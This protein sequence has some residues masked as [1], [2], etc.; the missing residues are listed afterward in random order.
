[1]VAIDFQ[2]EDAHC[3]LLTISP[4]TNTHAAQNQTSCWQLSINSWTL[5]F[6]LAR[7]T[8]FVRLLWYDGK[9]KFYLARYTSLRTS[10]V[11]FRTLRC[12]VIS[13]LVEKSECFEYSDKINVRKLSKRTN[14]NQCTDNRVACVLLVICKQTYLKTGCVDLV[15]LAHVLSCFFWVKLISE[16]KKRV[17]LA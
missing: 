2:N 6:V 16:C 9:S 10:R 4:V 17:D 1:M 14:N 5:N 7:V 11:D 12:S 13:N 15:F 3:W 8:T